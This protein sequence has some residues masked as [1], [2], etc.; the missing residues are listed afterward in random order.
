M[1]KIDIED[2][3]RATP[4]SDKLDPRPVKSSTEYDEPI[5]DM[6]KRDMADP[7]SPM[8]LNDNELPIR[9]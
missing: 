9:R 7:T 1:E 2:P 3:T 4:R 8:L 6:P 5:L